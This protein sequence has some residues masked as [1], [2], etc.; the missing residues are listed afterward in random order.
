MGLNVAKGGQNM[1]LCRTI[2]AVARAA[3]QG[4]SH[5]FI[6]NTGRLVVKELLSITFAGL[7]QNFSF[8]ACVSFLPT[9]KTVRPAAGGAPP[10]VATPAQAG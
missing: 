2:L 9:Q 8:N 5:D 1:G 3:A 4:R 7:G 6:W 10:R